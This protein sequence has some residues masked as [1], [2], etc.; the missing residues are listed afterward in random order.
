MYIHIHIF[1]YIYI[2]ALIEKSNLGAH[3]S[4]RVDLQPKVEITEGAEI[5]ELPILRQ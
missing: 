3:F 1:I 5:R 4:T 2:N